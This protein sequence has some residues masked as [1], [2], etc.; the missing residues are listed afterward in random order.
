[1]FPGP[2]KF[3]TCDPPL[4]PGHIQFMSYFRHY[5]TCQGNVLC[6]GAGN[7]IPKFELYSIQATYSPHDISGTTLLVKETCSVLVQEIQSRNLNCTAYRIRNV[8]AVFP[9]LH[10]LSRKRALSW[11]RKFVPEI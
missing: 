5:I 9:A 1:M 3:N 4:G 10:Y 7:W 8:H 6:P 11:C 2:G